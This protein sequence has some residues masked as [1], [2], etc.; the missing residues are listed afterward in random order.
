MSQASM[1]RRMK[2]SQAHINTIENRHIEIRTE[3]LLRMITVLGG[4]IVI[5][6][7]NIADEGYETNE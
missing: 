7:K 1:A 6:W 5:V 3:T 2:T 4:N